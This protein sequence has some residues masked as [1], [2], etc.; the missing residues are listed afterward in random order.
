MWKARLCLGTDADFG[1]PIEEQIRLFRQVGFDG[2][3]TE[4]SEAADISGWR[5][6]ADSLHITYQSVHAPFGRADALWQEGTA[7]ECAVEELLACLKDCV[8][9][10]IPIMVMHAFI[11]FGQHT[12]TAAG[13]ENFKKI[14]DAADRL[15]VKIALENTEGE[16]YLAAL[17]EA[18][19]GY[20]QVGFCWD[21]GHEMCYNHAQDLLAAYGDRLLCTHLNDNLGIRDFSGEITWRDDLHLLPF[22]G[23]ADWA[24]IARRLHRCGYSG[25][26]TLELIKTS[27]P[28]RHENDAYA[29][30]S[31]EEYV[32][33]AYKRGCRIAALKLREDKAAG[34]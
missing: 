28:G 31:M 18:F 1:I 4:W 6:L 20:E 16:E 15:G 29:A 12:P 25:D 30:M 8:K 5:R 23:I 34:V 22:D 33:E 9:N 3:F 19:R 32:T 2:F 21:S 13:I 14:A 10:E 17:M 7:A 27:K 26:L 11:G 24:E